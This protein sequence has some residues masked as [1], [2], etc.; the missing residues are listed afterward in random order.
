MGS[1]QNV[2]LAKLRISGVFQEKIAISLSH[3]VI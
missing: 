1:K 3:S 2:Q